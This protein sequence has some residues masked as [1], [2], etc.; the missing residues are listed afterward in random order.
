MPP[1]GGQGAEHWQQ[2]RTAGNLR[3]KLPSPRQP[4]W[5]FVTEELRYS[6]ELNGAEALCA[7][8]VSAA[9]LSSVAP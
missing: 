6:R 3:G 4:L 7:P 9:R 1:A 2:V 8:A 5:L